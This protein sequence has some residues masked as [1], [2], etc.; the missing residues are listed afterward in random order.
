MSPVL[1]KRTRHTTNKQVWVVLLWLSKVMTNNTRLWVSAWHLIYNSL[2]LCWLPENPSWL[3]ILAEQHIS[4]YFVKIKLLFHLSSVF[5]PE[6]NRKMWAGPHSSA[7]SD[8]P[9]SRLLYMYMLYEHCCS[10]WLGVVK[11]AYLAI[12]IKCHH[13]N[14]HTGNTF[15]LL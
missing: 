7:A 5:S 15:W 8:F 3:T 11:F 2:K 1:L 4:T 9:L 12:I 14:N 6:L 13:N 10:S